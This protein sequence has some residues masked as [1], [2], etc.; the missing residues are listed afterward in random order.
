[1][2]VSRGVGKGRERIVY[3]VTGVA[4]NCAV[5]GFCLSSV[6]V[7]LTEIESG[8]LHGRAEFDPS[9]GDRHFLGYYVECNEVD[10]RIRVMARELGLHASE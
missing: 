2:P 10:S 4:T 8:V 7:Q 9:T 6:R 5:W 1:M 3:T